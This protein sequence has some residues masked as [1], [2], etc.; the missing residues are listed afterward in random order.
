MHP[1]RA[2]TIDLDDTLWEIAPVIRRAEAEVW[3]WM[4]RNRPAVCE[5]FTAEA[6]VELRDQ[7]IREHWQRTH[8]FRFL[9]RMALTR[10]LETCGYSD[11]CIDEAFEVF[12]RFRNRVELFPDVLPSLQRLSERFTLVAVT[13]G[14][15]NLQTIGI[16]H[17]FDDVV[18]AV[19]VGAA[20]PARRIFDEAVR[21]A[22]AS[23]IETL[24]VG[25]HPECDIAGA[26]AAGLCTAWMNRTG[27]TWPE[28]LAAPDAV[29]TTV[30]ELHAILG[31]GATVASR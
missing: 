30:S 5:R 11:D 25:D 6:V 9:R 26:Q 18:S 1:I 4:E 28:H 27:G 17:L 31:H 29:V 10:M 24:H 20:K 12:D 22:G 8:D 21:R 14:N 15:A 7:V 23:A 19:E 3:R 2:I 16:R 13:N